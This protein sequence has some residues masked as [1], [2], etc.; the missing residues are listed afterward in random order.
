MTLH[1]PAGASAGSRQACWP[2]AGG[3]LDQDLVGV[4]DPGK[5]V[6]VG[7]P[8]RDVPAN[9][10]TK[11]GTPVTGS[12]DASGSPDCDPIATPLA[13]TPNTAAT[14]CDPIAYNDAADPKV[15]HP[16]APAVGDHPALGI[17]TP[18]HRGIPELCEVV[19]D[20]LEPVAVGGRSISTSGLT[21]PYAQGARTLPPI[22]AAS[23]LVLHPRESECGRV[24]G[25]TCGPRR[26]LMP[27]LVATQGGVV[28]VAC[29][30]LPHGRQ[31]PAVARFLG[32]GLLGSGAPTR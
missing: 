3:G 16:P 12:L 1:R 6:A 29:C 11:S 26:H 23:A 7:V 17:S 18:F 19:A 20:G 27:A 21:A 32:Y 28:A 5:R 8:R 13:G 9:R 22:V 30:W 15:E 14:P 24:L 25:R 31:D 10:A 2:A 4:L